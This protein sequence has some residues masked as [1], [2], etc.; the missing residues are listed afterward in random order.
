[1]NPVIVHWYIKDSYQKHKQ[2]KLRYNYNQ[3]TK[4]ENLQCYGI[5]HI[6]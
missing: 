2:R 1:M 6:M 3:N 5:Y 4:T